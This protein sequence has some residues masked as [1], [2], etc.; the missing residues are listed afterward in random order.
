MPNENISDDEARKQRAAR[1]RGQIE[2][3]KK[4]TCA[5]TTNP[6][7]PREFINKKMRERYGRTDS[8]EEKREGT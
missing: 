8:D 5:P 2:S 4:K 7:K 1:L 6:V 3:I